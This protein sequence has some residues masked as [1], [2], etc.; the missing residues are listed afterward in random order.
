MNR[1]E[2]RVDAP[3]E[4]KN[5]PVDAPVKESNVPVRDS[6]SK[7]DEEKI[8]EFCITPQGDFRDCSLLGI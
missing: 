7:T 5:A 4:G 3:V 8:L 2:K 6:L 1:S